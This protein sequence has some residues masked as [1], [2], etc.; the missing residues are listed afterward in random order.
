[1]RQSGFYWVKY[2]GKWTIAEYTSYSG[3]S[4]WYVTGN[5]CYFISEEFDEIDENRIPDHEL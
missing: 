1:M 3:Q 5:D 4:E 2:D